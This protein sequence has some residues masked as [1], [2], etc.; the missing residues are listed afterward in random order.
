VLRLTARVNTLPGDA[1][2][3]DDE[4]TA[5]VTV[6]P[7]GARIRVDGPASVPEGQT[8]AM[9][10]VLFNDSDSA[11]S[12][13][14]PGQVALEPGGGENLFTLV[15]LPPGC[16]TDP[17][18]FFCEDATTVP[19]GGSR[20]FEF[21]V[22]TL[23]GAAGKV[24]TL[25]ARND[26]TEAGTIRDSADVRITAAGDAG[27]AAPAAP[28][29]AGPGGSPATEPVGTPAPTAELAATGA[30]SLPLTALGLAF[31]VLG[32]ALTR[33]RQVLDRR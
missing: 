9:Q 30:G 4:A 25:L 6:V 2:P 33:C 5:T 10:V 24:F 20:T 19:A 13:E 29:P 21:R 11:H 22:R 26:P 1:E 3:A 23:H 7:L 14:L 8:F 15:S 17:L 16:G 12:A 31:V 32:A 18:S 27:P 28:A